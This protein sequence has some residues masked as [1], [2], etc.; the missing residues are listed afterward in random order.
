MASNWL[1][2]SM[3]GIKCLKSIDG[4]NGFGFVKF[5]QIKFCF[6]L[7]SLQLGL[8]IK[9]NCYWKGLLKKLTMPWFLVGI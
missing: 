7:N 8:S 5:A 2:D 9:S 4:R 3:H 1:D 6:V